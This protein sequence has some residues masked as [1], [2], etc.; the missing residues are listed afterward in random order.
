[1]EAKTKKILRNE[2]TFRLDYYVP[3]LD[4]QRSR[5]AAAPGG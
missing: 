4:R 1:M 3:P 2:L 5:T